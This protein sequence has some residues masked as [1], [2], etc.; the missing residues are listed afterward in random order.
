MF[1]PTFGLLYW[2]YYFW[3]I[4]WRFKVPLRVAFF[5]WTTALGN[6]LTIDN[7][8]KRKVKIIDWCYMCNCNGEFADHLLLHCPIVS[9]LWSMIFG[10]FGKFL[11]DAKICSWASSLLARSIWSSSKWSH[12]DDYPT[13]SDVVHL[14]GKE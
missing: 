11:G 13:L 6:I 4:I 2:Y 9:D 8:R 10:L 1:L 7:L 14:E 3:K 5:L 12:L